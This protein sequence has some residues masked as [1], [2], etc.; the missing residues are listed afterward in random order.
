MSVRLPYHLQVPA[1]TSTFTRASDTRKNTNQ[2]YHRHRTEKET[3]HSYLA[4]TP[5]YSAQR[6]GPIDTAWSDNVIRPRRLRG[7]AK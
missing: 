6:P 7:L 4:A 1:D 5:A 2:F 3:R